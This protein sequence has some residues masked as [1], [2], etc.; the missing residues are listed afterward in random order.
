MGGS[1]VH[2]SVV[3]EVAAPLVRPWVPFPPPPE[4]LEAGL[5]RRATSAPDEVVGPES[6]PGHPVRAHAHGQPRPESMDA[7]R[8]SLA[9]PTRLT[10]GTAAGFHER[11]LRVYTTPPD[12]CE[13]AGVAK[14]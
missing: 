12:R 9:G 10:A 4:P 14:Q 3:I 11:H 1:P 5:E 6:L 7:I 13:I 2:G 8:G